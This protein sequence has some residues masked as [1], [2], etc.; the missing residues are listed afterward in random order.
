[1]TTPTH[2]PNLEEAMPEVD[3]LILCAWNYM[4]RV[5]RVKEVTVSSKPI[6]M[7]LWKPHRKATDLISARYVP[8]INDDEPE[9]ISITRAQVKARRLDVD[10]R[11]YFLPSTRAVLKKLLRKWRS[12]KGGVM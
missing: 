10:D 4:P 2:P 8:S 6:S 1:M 9:I 5:G 7:H 11:G 12:R 3:E